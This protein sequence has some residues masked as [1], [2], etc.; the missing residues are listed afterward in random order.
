MLTIKVPLSPEGWD[1]EKQEFIEP[2]YKT[3][4]LEHS[5]VSLHKWE[6]KWHKAFLKEKSE[7]TDEEVLDYIKCMTITQNVD[8][9]VYNHLSR[10]NYEQIKEYINDPMTSTVIYENKK[11]KKSSKETPTAE[12]IYYW[13]ISLGIP[14]EY[15]KWH[16]NQL[17]T[18]I[19]VFEAKNSDAPKMSKQ[20]IMSRNKALNAARRAKLHSKG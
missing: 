11:N 9:D 15:R 12:L 8:P 18:L 3:L 19:R 2:E 10:E 4:Q 14:P 6:S 1:E 7:K 13:M 20:E 16:I 5:L 17:I